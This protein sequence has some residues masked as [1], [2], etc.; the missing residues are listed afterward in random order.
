MRRM[1]SLKQI[2]EIADARVEA[3]V[4]GG[5]LDNAKPIYWHG[6]EMLNSGSSNLTYFT[7]HILN[8]DPTPITSWAEVEAIIRS[9]TA[10]FTLEAHGKID[11]S[12]T[13]RDLLSIFKR[14]NET[15]I[16]VVYMGDTKWQSIDEFNFGNVIGYV[17]DGVN[18]IN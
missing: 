5:T 18:K 12:G 6:L 2:K 13:S 7:C 3:L 16:N 17:Y 15:K 9:T 10:R 8:N 11:I 4:E 1:F 14:A